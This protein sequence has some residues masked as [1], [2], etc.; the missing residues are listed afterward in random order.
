MQ[1]VNPRPLTTTSFALLGLLSVRP[2]SAYELTGQMKRGMRH[3]WP[4][5]ET[6]VYQEPKNLVAHGLA[7]AASEMNHRIGERHGIG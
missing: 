1:Y 7:N 6:R 4:R 5:T 2:W 3:T